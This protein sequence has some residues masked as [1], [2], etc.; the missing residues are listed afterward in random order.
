A[1]AGGRGTA[2]RV[3]RQVQSAPSDA[4]EMTRSAENTALVTMFTSSRDLGPAPAGRPARA[5]VRVAGV[6]PPPCAILG[7]AG[8]APHRPPDEHEIA[9][10][11]DRGS[12]SADRGEGPGGRR[13][14]RAR[15]PRPWPTT[16]VAGRRAPVRSSRATTD[17]PEGPHGAGRSLWQQ[18]HD[19]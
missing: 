1:V 19:A 11:A 4:H 7:G 8:W 2:H 5:A 9:A 17:R 10:P 12:R 13:P 3:R 18:E 6:G 14:R 15:G 16:S